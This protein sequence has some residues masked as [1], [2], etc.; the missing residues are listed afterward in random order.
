MT[1]G[2]YSMSS[3]SGTRTRDKILIREPLYQ[4]RYA[5]LTLTRYGV[6]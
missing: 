5:A 2:A 6:V 4:L 3:G 1:R